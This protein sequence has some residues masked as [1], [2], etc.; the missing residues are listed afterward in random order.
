MSKQFR[1]ITTILFFIAFIFLILLIVNNVI[2][3]SSNMEELFQGSGRYVFSITATLSVILLLVPFYSLLTY[4]SIPIYKFDNNQE[5]QKVL[6]SIR[7][8]LKKNPILK[9][10][11]KKL[12]SEEEIREASLYLKKEAEKESVRMAEF[13]FLSTAISQNGKLDSLIVFWQQII[14]VHRIT[15]I[16]SGSIGFRGILRLYYNVAISAFMARSLEDIELEEYLEPLF[17]ELLASSA[18]S[19]VPGFSTI[20]STVMSSMMEGVSNAFLTLRVG[21]ITSELLYP[22]SPEEKGKLRKKAV[23]RA[24]FL[25]F[26]VVRKTGGRVINALKKSAWNYSKKGMKRMS[27]V[28]RRKR[29]DRDRNVM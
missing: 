16:Y 20:A 8:Y 4:K 7:T 17:E 13:V 26:K 14:L 25:L 5:K 11:E 9:K 29:E 21:L 28:F 1:T 6:D 18:I 15:V 10:E 2:E 23:S 3:F 24:A 12:E 22:F 19:T 27:N